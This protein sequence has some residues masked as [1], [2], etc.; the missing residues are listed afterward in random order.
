MGANLDLRM[1]IIEIIP[2]GQRG[3]HSVEI[4]KMLGIIVMYL[5]KSFHRSLTIDIADKNGW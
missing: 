2:M 3:H 5:A 1:G 4:A